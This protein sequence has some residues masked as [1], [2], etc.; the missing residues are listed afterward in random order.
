MAV[1]KKQSELREIEKDDTAK[2]M[3]LEPLFQKDI[4][5]LLR[6]INSEF[7]EQYIANQTV[8]DANEFKAEMMAVL[9]VNYKKITNKFKFNIRESFEDKVSE[10][11]N[12]QIN[13]DI[14]KYIKDMSN[15]K[16][17]FILDTTNKDIN[18]E[19]LI[20]IVGAIEEGTQIIDKEIAKQTK[21]ELNEKA[22]GRSNIIA[23]SET[24]NAAESSKEIEATILIAAGITL[25]GV[26]L[27]ENLRDVWMT[28][29]DE[30]T[31]IDHAIADGQQKFPE[32]SF[33]VGGELLRFPGDPQGSPGNI[34]NCRCSSVRKVF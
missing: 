34:I 6:K 2:K 1:A 30:R 13:N 29:L 20:A 32:E 25:D 15:I 12:A 8:I 7:E 4:L 10:E 19:L 5:K 11:V 9:A 33:F 17:D 18:N 28:I 27:R 31:R 26:N 16:S 24:E 21:K 3:K 22:I 14:N 23:I